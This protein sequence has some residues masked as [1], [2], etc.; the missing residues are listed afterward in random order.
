MM[1][2]NMVVFLVT[3]L[4]TWGRIATAADN[5]VT[6]L[7]DPLQRPAQISAQAQRAVMLAAVHAGDHLVAAGERGIIL[8]S[9]DNGASWTQAVVPVS[10]TLT[11]LS[12]PTAEHGWAVGHGGV[13]LHTKNGGRSWERQLDGRALA[14]IELDSARRK[15]DEN[16]IKMAQQLVGHGP[17]KPLLG[18]HF[19]DERRGFAIGAYGL[20]VGTEDGG[21]SW[22]SWIDRVDNPR[23]LHLNA[24]YATR[25]EVYLA[26]EQGIILRSSDG[27]KTFRQIS[28]PY[29]GSWFV[30][31][32]HDGYL[33][34]GG[35]RGNA[36]RS[37]D[38]GATWEALQASAPVTL[39]SA[40]LTKD[41]K[42][43]IGN[44]AGMLMQISGNGLRLASIPSPI[45]QPITAMVQAKNGSLLAATFTGLKSLV[46][47]DATGVAS[48]R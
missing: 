47:S 34:V 1:K 24:L 33:L 8:W 26:G 48:G 30:L 46:H 45:G 17:D 20:I 41:G 37:P 42:I 38:G 23:G 6:P 40:V 18:V 22:Q 5:G 3:L 13:V 10:V 16:R 32:G 31:A 19:W 4:S 2:I 36:F 25:S 12:F 29:K 7:I 15:G 9:A 43:L 28:S 14:Q 21:A 11:A 35:L 39:T 44:L 27:A